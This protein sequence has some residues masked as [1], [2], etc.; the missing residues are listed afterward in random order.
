MEGDG[1]GCKLFVGVVLRDDVLLGDNDRLKDGAA[2]DL[3]TDA[4]MDRLLLLE[5]LEE[6][7]SE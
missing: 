1:V 2:R 3:V 7:D 4:T 5:I 6:L